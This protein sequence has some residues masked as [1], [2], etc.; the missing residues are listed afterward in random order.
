M[1]SGTTQGGGSVPLIPAQK[2]GPSGSATLAQQGSDV[3]VTLQ[4]PT[5]YSSRAKVAIYNGSCKSTGEASAKGKALYTLTS[6]D[7]N[8]MSKTTIGN[9]TVE[10]LVGSPHVIVVQGSPPLCGDLANMLPPQKP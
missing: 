5:G 1:A 3:V 4:L 6:A 7:T 8:G 9:V 2:K 10:K